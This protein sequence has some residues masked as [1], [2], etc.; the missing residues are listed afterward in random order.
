MPW[1]HVVTAVTALCAVAASGCRFLAELSGATA[2]EPRAMQRQSCEGHG[3]RYIDVAD[4]SFAN[5][6]RDGHPTLSTAWMQWLQEAVPQPWQPEGVLA[7]MD[8]LRDNGGRVSEALALRA[9][10]VEIRVERNRPEVH[11]AEIVRWDALYE[12]PAASCA[13]LAQLTLSSG[14]ARQF[15]P[16]QDTLNIVT[17]LRL[18][19]TLGLPAD[20]DLF[21]DLA[22]RNTAQTWLGLIVAA[23]ELALSKGRVWANELRPRNPHHE[24]Q[25]LV[26]HD[27]Y[28]GHLATE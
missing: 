7:K 25:R 5:G 28:S 20:D 16:R 13:L 24:E 21:L 18:L 27:Y 8:E 3:G 11:F 17:A 9:G 6:C 22:Q 10:C 14:S 4:T 26:W 19:A 15:R 12:C 2:P 23:L 1:L